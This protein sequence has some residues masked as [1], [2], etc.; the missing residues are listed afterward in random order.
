VQE[1]ADPFDNDWQRTFEA[2]V[3]E[4]HARVER[5]NRA[6][7]NELWTLRDLGPGG[8]ATPLVLGFAILATSMSWL[9][10]E[11][12]WTIRA[13]LLGLAI[14]VAAASASH[15]IRQTRS[16]RAQ[17]REDFAERPRLPG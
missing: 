9:L 11:A 6:E 4:E 17:Q 13:M 1:G 15:A 3:A 10:T 14:A 16:R 2:S 7:R 5:M 12:S 8:R